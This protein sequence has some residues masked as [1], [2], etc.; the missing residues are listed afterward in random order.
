MN[1]LT[2]LTGQ[3]LSSNICIGLY[4]NALEMTYNPNE[5][6]RIKN[7]S[8]SEIAAGNKW[9]ENTASWNL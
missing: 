6:K 7:E 9:R 4:R 5:K 3:M 2:D 8:P 1:G